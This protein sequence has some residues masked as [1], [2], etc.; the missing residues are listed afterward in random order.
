MDIMV[1]IIV[2]VYNVEQYLHECV[3]SILM[4]NYSNYEVILVDDG[5]KDNSGTICDEYAKKN[6]KVSVIH[7]ENQGLS[8]ARNSGVQ[9]SKGKYITFVDSDDFISYDYIRLLVT[10]IRNDCDVVTTGMVKFSEVVPDTS[11]EE[12]YVEELSNEEALRILC[13][14][15]KFG[16]SACAKLYKRYLVEKYPYPV[17]KLYED[18]ATT[19]KIIG[20]AQGICF[21]SKKGYYY[22]QR[23][24][25]IRKLNYHGIESSDWYILDAAKN[26]Y[27]YI[28]ERY[29]AAAIAAKGR[30]V[31][32]GFELIR[33]I[34]KGTREDKENF[35]KIQLYV[36]SFRKDVLTSSDVNKKSKIKCIAICSGYYPAVACSALFDFMRMTIKK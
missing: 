24:Y 16:N 29:P 12:T 35:Q 15:T 26:Q 18:L 8:G 34:R 3:D 22:R 25:S 28:K 13:N 33:L 20:D 6:S 36:K 10:S 17:G 7:Q 30:C 14:Q 27:E 31:V 32:A 9:V 21:C 23:A 11:K 1:S 2:P 4:Q 19:Y 5:S